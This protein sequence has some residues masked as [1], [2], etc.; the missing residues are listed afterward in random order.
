MTSDNIKSAFLVPFFGKLPPYFSFWA[1]SCEINHQNFHWF[2]YNDQ[3][4]TGYAVNKAV[5][6]IPYQFD[7]MMAD[8]QNILNIRLPG[9]YLRKICDYRIMFYFLRRHKEPLD[10]FDFIGYTD[11]DMIYG[12]LNRFLPSDMKRY[13]IISGDNN[14]PCGPFTLTD[15]SSMKFLL[16]SDKIKCHFEAQEHNSFNESEELM[17]IVSEDKPV[18]CHSDPIQP[19]RTSGF[20]YRRTF[21]V[22]NNGSV[23]VWDHKGNKK[24]GGFYHFSRYKDK[25]RFKISE[26]AIHK[27]RW[28]VY[29]YGITPIPSKWTSLKLGLSLFI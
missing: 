19:T 23:T 24:E 16:E 14:Q 7:E 21:A 1:K 13:S 26:D 9:Q 25:E 12:R 2:V 11:M 17:N 3:T 29:K 8:F 27:Q 6:V 20:S 28:A 5:S 15:R 4:D 10:D 22:W 18:F